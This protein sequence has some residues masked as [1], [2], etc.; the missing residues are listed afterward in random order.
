[1]MCGW[2]GRA[3]KRLRASA[4]L[5][6]GLLVGAAWAAEVGEPAQQLALELVAAGDH[7]GAA[8]EYRRLAL[9]EVDE[10]GRAAWLWAAAR[11][12]LRAGQVRAAEGALDRAEAAGLASLPL[13]LMRAETAVA[14]GDRG[15]AEFYWTSIA[16]DPGVPAEA[17][18][19]GARRAAALRA[20]EGRW[21]DAA[22]ALAAS[23]LDESARLRRIEQAGSRPRRV[24]WVGGLLGLV[25]GLG[26]VYSGEYANG[27]RSLIL[28]G[29]FLGLLALAMDEEQW[30]AAGAIGFLEVTWYSGSIYGGIDAAHRWNRRIFEDTAAE[31][32]RGT[33]WSF[34]ERALPVLRLKFEL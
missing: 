30:A 29:I 8:V 17:R 5:L 18:A 11:E 9:R 10:A 13:R 15:A 16:E 19:M 34:D 7:E 3:A 2:A 27:A 32:E 31:L 12:H 4:R 33:Q 22:R 6:S 20:R 1:M 25:P 23:P 28:N 14:A 26:Y 24:P 21:E